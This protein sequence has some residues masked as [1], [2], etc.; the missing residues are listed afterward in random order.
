MMPTSIDM[1]LAY[2]QAKNAIQHRAI[3]RLAIA[4]WET[5]LSI[6]LNT[7]HNKLL[8]GSPSFDGMEIG[9]SWVVPKSVRFKNENDREGDPPQVEG[10][11]IQMHV[12]LTMEQAIVEVLWLWEFGPVFESFLS[13]GVYA[14]R[15]RLIDGRSRV[16]KLDPQLFE[17]WPKRYQEYR[18]AGIRTARRLLRE[19]ERCHLITLDVM[20]YYDSVNASFLLSDRFTNSLAAVANS[21]EI[22]FDRSHYI[23]ST[24]SLLDRFRDFYRQCEDLTGIPTER[25]L[26]IGALSSRVIAN[27]ALQ[28]LDAILQDDPDN[29]FYGRY[30]DDILVVSKKEIA[31]NNLQERVR[32]VLSGYVPLKPAD[33]N[34]QDIELDESVIGRDGCILRLQPEKI[35]IY[36]LDGIRGLDFLEAVQRDLRIIGSERRAFLSPESLDTGSNRASALSVGEGGKAHITVLREADRVKLQRYATSVE[37]GK[38]ATAVGLLGMP[39]SSSWCASHIGLLLRTATNVYHWIDFLDLLIR[40]QGICF[41]A[42]DYS[43]ATFIAREIRARCLE[44]PDTSSWVW[45]GRQVRNSDA[46]ERF[47]EWIEQRQVEELCSAIPCE[48]LSEREEFDKALETLGDVL[49]DELNQVRASENALLLHLADLRTAHVE[50]DFFRRPLEQSFS[51]ENRIGDLVDELLEAEETSG[52][53][54]SIEVFLEKCREL[55]D[56]VYRDRSTVEM[57]IMTRPP[58]MLDISLRLQ[59]HESHL[60]AILTNAIRGTKYDVDLIRFNQTNY[61]IDIR[62]TLR[63][64]TQPQ[65]CVLVLGNLLTEPHY[66]ESAAKG[67]PISDPLRMARLGRLANQ[68]IE[69]SRMNRKPTVLLLPE[70]SLPRK[71]LRSLGKKLVDEEVGLVAGL[72]YTVETSTNSVKNEAVGIFPLGMH[73]SVGHLWRKGRPAVVEEKVLAGLGIGFSQTNSR[74]PVVDTVYG[75]LSVL[76]CSELLEVNARA[77]LLGKIDLLLVPAWNL[78]TS[79]FEHMVQTTAMDLHAF[80]GLANNANYS[81]CRVRVPAKDHF[82]RDIARLIAPGQNEC[83]SVD[84][85]VRRLRKFQLEFEKT[86]LAG[87]G[88]NPEFKPLPPGYKYLRPR[89]TG[90]L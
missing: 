65:P 69:R 86:G 28:P 2:R 64:E 33:P 44:M 37:I 12:Q 41:I 71:W 89:S 60:L 7:L 77:E 73:S 35:R 31:G 62:P 26:P 74:R 14:N 58:T 30:V 47:T 6:R 25:G 87:L 23:D 56:E 61:S 29:R 85:D 49:S 82:R 20:S 57:M 88:A 8:S 75:S 39:H 22:E 3:G 79:T 18:D 81:D 27:L 36:S 76:I 80:V 17:Y 55:D 11:D 46:G 66:L 50:D 59:P 4:R 53:A 16:N 43:S 90:G 48:V 38:L 45:N 19:G 21:N 24:Q 15:L 5:G 32:S 10:I 34:L 68:A 83:I 52:L 51:A 13:R 67:F 40:A 42:H 63:R 84:I 54:E 72:E 70:L 78:D 9:Q 1:L